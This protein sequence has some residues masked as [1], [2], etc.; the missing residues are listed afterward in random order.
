MGR[1]A[2][3]VAFITGTVGGQGRAAA[4]LFAK[5]GAHVIGCDLKTADAH[6]TVELV[7]AQGGRMDSV[8]PVDLSDPDA[9]K[10]WIEQGVA[11]AGRI[12]ILYNNASA[13]K[14]AP[15]AEMT[16]A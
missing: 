16:Q 12:D 8:C 9:A 2:N 13:V 4:L 7:R 11:K 10:G 15:V 14:F 5:E 6:E 3:K 1:L